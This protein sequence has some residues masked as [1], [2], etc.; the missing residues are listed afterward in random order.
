MGGGRQRLGDLPVLEALNRAFASRA[1]LKVDVRLWRV[2]LATYAL[3]LDLTVE[4]HF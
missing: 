4:V 2:T 3:K 1:M